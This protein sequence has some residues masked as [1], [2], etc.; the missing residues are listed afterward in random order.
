MFIKF[1]L[2]YDWYQSASLSWYLTTIW[3]PWPTILPLQWKLSSDICICLV[4]DERMGLKFT[5][6]CATE[7]CQWCHSRVLVLQYSRPYL[8]VSFDTEF[9]FCRLLRLT[10]LRWK[11][12]NRP[13]SKTTSV[14]YLDNLALQIIEYIIPYSLYKTRN[15]NYYGRFQHLT[16]QHLNLTLFTF[17]DFKYSWCHRIWDK[18]STST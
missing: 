6:T 2:S 5:H 16:V 18:S 9:L 17:L 7:P 3:D 8:T 14:Q 10:G 1:K 12:S 15:I 4:W 13:S 11:Y